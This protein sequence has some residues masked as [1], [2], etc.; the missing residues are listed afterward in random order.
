M[1]KNFQDINS[2]LIRIFSKKTKVFKEAIEEDKDTN[3]VAWLDS[4]NN[5]NK[6]N[7]IKIILKDI[8]IGLE[9]CNKEELLHF[10]EDLDQEEIL[11]KG[12]HSMIEIK[13]KI[14]INLEEIDQGE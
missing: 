1:N 9:I 4:N 14:N 6:S 12:H 10:V 7:L 13:T 2:Q 11:I 5:N 8:I 3:N